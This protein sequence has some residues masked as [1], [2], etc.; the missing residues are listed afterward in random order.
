MVTAKLLFYEMMTT[1][2]KWGNWP[3]VEK[4]HGEKLQDIPLQ[5]NGITSWFYYTNV[6]IESKAEHLEISVQVKGS[7][8]AALL[9]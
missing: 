6:D 2:L 9:K 4:I 7:N 8:L 3:Y 1:H 5:S